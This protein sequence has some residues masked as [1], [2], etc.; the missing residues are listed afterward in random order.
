MERGKW[1]KREMRVGEFVE[2]CSEAEE[3][4]GVRSYFLKFDNIS[5]KVDNIIQ[6]SIIYG[7][8]SIIKSST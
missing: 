8:N 4:E 6:K 2:L 1:W 7:P 3:W 5:C